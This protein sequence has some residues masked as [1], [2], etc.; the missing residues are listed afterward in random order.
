MTAL[1]N[2]P[3]PALVDSLVDRLDSCTAGHAAI[4][5]IRLAPSTRVTRRISEIQAVNRLARK[6]TGLNTDVAH[7]PDGTPYIPGFDGYVSVT[8][9]AMM[10]LMAVSRHHRTGIDA[11]CWR[12]Q[13]L[14]VAPRFLRPEEMPVHAA[15][16]HSLLRAWTAKEAIFKALGISGITLIDIALPHNIEGPVEVRVDGHGTMHMTLTFFDHMPLCVAV[17]ELM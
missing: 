5:A 9:G 8:H 14:R 15:S 1:P 3:D 6:A 12:E 17:A 2:L 13:L 16:P 4:H 7:H 10:A 11:E